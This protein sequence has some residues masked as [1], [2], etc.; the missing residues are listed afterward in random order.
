[1][2]KI[3]DHEGYRRQLLKGSFDLFAERGYA[4]I[5]MRELAASLGVSTG[6]LY[7]YFPGK[8]AIFEAL[9][10][11]LWEQDVLMAA[12]LQALPPVLEKRV[13]A[14]I[15]FLVAHRDYFMKQTALWLDFCRC[16]GE[17]AAASNPAAAR[18]V[19]RFQTWLGNYL[20]IDDPT[21]VFFA[22]CFLDGLVLD[23]AFARGE[24]AA[25]NQAVVLSLALSAA[26]EWRCVK[27][28][29]NAFSRSPKDD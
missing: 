9:V 7:H 25:K 14:L 21:L 10:D 6:T 22:G 2:P 13:E 26:T 28:E 19:E 17:E 20:Q 15:D 27:E 3:V 18:S 1:M 16:H 8:Q 11:F 5:T 4:A 29:R 12:A 23:L 24:G